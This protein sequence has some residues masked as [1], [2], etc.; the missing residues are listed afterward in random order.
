MSNVSIFTQLFT[1]SKAVLTQVASGFPTATDEE[2]K[3][4]AEI[5]STCPFLN[6]EE[7]KCNKC[8]CFLKYKIPWAT[9]E[10]PLNNWNKTNE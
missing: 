10:C 7:Y 5:C 9:S 6:K 1:F 2:I 8:G 4:R 3:K